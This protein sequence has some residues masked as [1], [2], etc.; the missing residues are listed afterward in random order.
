MRSKSSP[1]ALGFRLAGT[2]VVS[3]V[4]AGGQ[5]FAEAAY[6]P[7]TNDGREPGDGTTRGPF[8][9]A[10]TASARCPSAPTDATAAARRTVTSKFLHDLLDSVRRSRW[11]TKD[12]QWMNERTN[13]RNKE[14]KCRQWE[15]T[16]HNNGMMTTPM[17][18]MDKWARFAGD[19]WSVAALRENK[20]EQQKEEEEELKRQFNSTERIAAKG[21][22]HNS[23]RAWRCQLSRFVW[24]GRSGART[25][26]ENQSYVLYVPWQTLRKKPLQ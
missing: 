21:D 25:R 23:H 5:T 2:V 20:R 13:E 26:V 4:A 12:E 17:A 6:E 22:D 10:W 8:L 18:M 16:T 7:W 9:R 24:V 14:I 1:P 19:G 3:L 11:S 15:A